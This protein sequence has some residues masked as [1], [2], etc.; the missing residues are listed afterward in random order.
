MFIIS[1]IDYFL[2]MWSSVASAGTPISK[3]GTLFVSASSKPHI[4]KLTPERK[5]LARELMSMCFRRIS[6]RNWELGDSSTVVSKDVLHHCYL[7]I[8]H[9]KTSFLNNSPK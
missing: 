8:T 6:Y 5:K 9:Q 2:F 7:S 4:G 3:K 1:R